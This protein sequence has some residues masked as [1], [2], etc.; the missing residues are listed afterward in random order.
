MQELK[1]NN[2]K[3]CITDSKLQ[4]LKLNSG[5][6]YLQAIKVFQTLTYKALS[7]SGEQVADPEGGG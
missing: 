5:S 4:L 1:N 6:A 3:N 7:D 2:K